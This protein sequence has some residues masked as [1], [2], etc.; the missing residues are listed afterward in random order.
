MKFEKLSE[1][2]IRITLTPGDF[3]EKHIDFQDFMSNP[4]ES[5]DLFLDILEEAKSQIGFNTSDY[6]VKIEALA[7]IDGDFVVNVTRAREPNIEKS[8]SNSSTGRR[9]FKVKR[10]AKAPKVEQAVYKFETFDDYCNFTEYLFKS[11]LDKSY[12]IA[13]KI[14]TYQYQNKYYLVFYNINNNDK[15]VLK[16]YSSITEFGTYVNNSNLLIS[17]IEE[18]GKIVIKNNALKTSLKHYIV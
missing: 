14:I 16:F 4:L 6:R 15:N 12:Q 11:N 7:M 3:E 18:Y 1:N 5:Q 2:K 10:K 8:S 13:K 17:K 9:K